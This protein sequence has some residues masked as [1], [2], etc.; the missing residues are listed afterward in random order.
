MAGLVHLDASA[1]V[2]LVVEEAESSA[3]REALR[4]RPRRV[5]SALALV[6][7][8]L[9]VGSRSPA[10]P[11]GRVQTAHSRR[12]RDA[13]DGLG[14]QA[15]TAGARRHSSGHRA[16][17]WRRPGVVDRLRPA[18][19]LRRP[20]RRPQNLR[21]PPTSCGP[22]AAQS[23]GRGSTVSSRGRAQLARVPPGG[24]TSPYDRSCSTSQLRHGAATPRRSGVDGRG[25]RGPSPPI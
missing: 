5:S 21:A 10:P 25:R 6:E 8:H 1:I 17:A 24:P 16:I 4:E 23:R 20:G 7:V 13:R 14:P 9:A 22:S 19:P 18:A 11:P 3:L 15:R 12:S 2:R